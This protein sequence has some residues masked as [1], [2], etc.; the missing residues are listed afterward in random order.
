MTISSVS[1]SA[2]KLWIIIIIVCFVSSQRFVTHDAL[3]ISKKASDVAEIES[4]SVIDCTR[5][6]KRN[7]LCNRASYDKLTKRCR[8]VN[9]ETSR[10][11]DVE[12]D[13]IQ[14][15]VF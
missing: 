3:S 14:T 9:D 13:V 15:S 10:N 12:M 8:I 4:G 11:C 7:N 6:C 2:Y 1:N 5:D